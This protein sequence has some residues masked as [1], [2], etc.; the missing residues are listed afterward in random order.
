MPGGDARDLH[1][2]LLS[3][4]RSIAS[5]RHE[6]DGRHHELP[7]ISGRE[8]S[9]LAFVRPFART[10]REQNAMIQKVAH[11]A[12]GAASAFE[13]CRKP[14]G[15]RPAPQR[16]DRGRW[17]R[18]ADTPGLQAGHGTFAPARFPELAGTHAGLGKMQFGFAHGAHEPEQKTI[19]EAGRIVDPVL[20][21]DA[22]R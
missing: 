5:G 21:E 12:H 1:V 10:L 15:S 9:E 22:W 17:R 14:T 18:R 19:I 2:T 7:L 11:P 8:P 4:S 20:F 3:T 6:R 13:G 16:R